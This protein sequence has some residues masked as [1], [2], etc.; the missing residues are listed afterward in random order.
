MINHVIRE[1]GVGI[2]VHV[3]SHPVGTVETAL[4]RTR[5]PSALP[6]RRVL[7]GFALGATAAPA[8]TWLLSH[9]REDVSLPSVL[10]LYL[11]LVVTVS[12]VGGVWPALAAA[13][14]SFLLANWYFTPPLYT[15][16]IGEGE[17]LLALTVFLAVAG[18]VSGFVALA[19]RRAAEGARARA[20]AGTLATLA[21]SAPVIEVIE[22]MRRA[23]GFDGA[24]VFHRESGGWRVD[25][26]TG[27]VPTTPEE[28]AETVEIDANHVLALA[29]T[30]VRRD[31]DR[32]ILDAFARELAASIQ[33]EELE[34]EASASRN[35]RR[36]Q[37][38]PDGD[39]LGRLTRPAYAACGHQ[40]LGHEPASGGHRLAP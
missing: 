25:A 24:A 2:D 23:F 9:L 14:G 26:A 4:P 36:R 35:S 34:S 40:G 17:N 10:L 21:G 5:R 3:I 32:R 37:R 30:P 1:S 19:A 38:P 18:V 6:R 13:V 11:L 22:S 27:E 31:D 16:T 33:L 29:G 15:F 28:A 12:A 8:L 7:L 20:E 39:P